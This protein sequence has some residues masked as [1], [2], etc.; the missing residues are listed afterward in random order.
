[1]VWNECLSVV[2]NTRL[3][4]MQDRLASCLFYGQRTDLHS[5]VTP[6]SVISFRLSFNIRYLLVTSRGRIPMASSKLLFSAA[7]MRHPQ[8]SA[9]LERPS[10]APRT[11]GNPPIPGTPVWGDLARAAVEV[12]AAHQRRF[13]LSV[14]LRVSSS[15][16]ALAFALSAARRWFAG[17]PPIGRSPTP[18]TG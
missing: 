18:I 2:N 7:T 9:H 8:S 14:A 15:E 12:L 17:S 11:A 13:W 6:R 10:T 16:S 3:I 4:G 1:M 5:S